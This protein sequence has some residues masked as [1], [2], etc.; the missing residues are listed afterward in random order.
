MNTPGLNNT[1]TSYLLWLT[2]LFGVSG[3]HRFY[4]KK[5]IS[6]TLWLLTW[7]FF[8]IGQFIDLFLMPS[9]VEEHNLRQ[10]AKLG[11]L[12]GGAMLSQPMIQVV[13]PSGA[14][15][16][17]APMPQ[18]D[19]ELKPD[20]KP[21]TQHDMMLKLL[22]AAQLRNGKLSVTQAVMDTELGFDQVETAMQEMVKMGYVAVENHPESGVVLYDFLEL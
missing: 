19:L 15:S 14:A 10:R 6:G 4:N 5:P 7:G 16:A 11:L 18:A 17:K 12:P 2:C 22:K 8:G 21:L 1:G 9:M 20:S 13:V 3:I